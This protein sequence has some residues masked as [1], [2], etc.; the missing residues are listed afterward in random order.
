MDKCGSVKEKSLSETQRKLTS[1]IELYH[2]QQNGIQK[3]LVAGQM[4]NSKVEEN[5]I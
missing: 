2:D 3:F 5:R 1:V 4:Y